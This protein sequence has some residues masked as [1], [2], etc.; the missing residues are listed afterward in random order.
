M[1]F[2]L[3]VG[4]ARVLFPFKAQNRDEL[5]LKVQDVVNVLQKDLPDKG[6]WLGELN[7][8]AGVF[9]DNFVRLLPNSVHTENYSFI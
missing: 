3:L 8:V 7:G 9:P 2:S 4:R 1:N 5:N 6:W